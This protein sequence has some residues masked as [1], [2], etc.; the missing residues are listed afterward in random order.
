MGIVNVQATKNAL[1]DKGGWKRRSLFSRPIAVPYQDGPLALIARQEVLPYNP[2]DSENWQDIMLTGSAQAGRDQS[3]VHELFKQNKFEAGVDWNTV[4]Y[5]A[6]VLAT[7]LMNSPQ[8]LQHDY[9]FYLGTNTPA[10]L[11]HGINPACLPAQRPMEYSCNKGIRELDAADIAAVQE[12]RLRLASRIRYQIR[13]LD[14]GS[15]AETKAEKP[16][17]YKN[18]S[19][20]LIMIGKHLY[21][22]ALVRNRTPEDEARVRLQVATTLLHEVAHAAHNHLFGTKFEDFREASIVAEAGYE[23][24]SRLFGLRPSIR[25]ED[26]SDGCWKTWQY[27]RVESPTRM[28]RLCRDMSELPEEGQKMF[29]QDDFVMKI[30]EDGFWSGEYAR[31]GALALLPWA[32]AEC[33]RELEADNVKDNLVMLQ[34]ISDLSGGPSYAKVLYSQSANPGLVLRNQQPDPV[35]RLGV[36]KAGKSPAQ[37]TSKRQEAEY[38]KVTKQPAKRPA[39]RPARK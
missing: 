7:R 19:G 26:P 1:G 30:C 25:R 6:A 16:T 27:S 2:S 11:P 5:D 17:Q 39:K 37:R 15:F 9:C 24:E 28:Q 22:L 35:V 36:P 8:G 10:D 20:S 4:F 34:S 18:G 13:D 29:M 23:F 14:E 31:D 21:N 33:C 32:A 38:C 3:L 12:E